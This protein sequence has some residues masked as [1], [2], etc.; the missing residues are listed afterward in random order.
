MKT[1]RKRYHDLSQKAAQFKKA[2]ESAPAKVAEIR[3]TIAESAGQFQKLKHDVQESVSGLH[4][5]SEDKLLAALAEIDGNLDVL[6]EAGYRLEGVEMEMGLNQR[7][8]VHLH[9]EE[10]VEKRTL[11]FLVK[12]NEGRATIHSILEALI[13]AEDVEEEVSLTN[14][15]YRELIVEAGVLPCVRLGW[16]TESHE[17]AAAPVTQNAPAPVP[18]PAPSTTTSGSTMFGQGSFFE[19]REP[20]ATQATP[21]AQPQAAPEAT[22]AESTHAPAAP[23]PEKAKEPATPATNDPLARFKKMPDLSKYRS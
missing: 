18:A 3:Q 5:D 1:F 10:E 22:H 20:T 16:W 23:A 15:K 7:L 21:P 9:K 17:E 14:M 19:R 4:A 2:L 11:L 13:K 12:Q 8:I 6:E